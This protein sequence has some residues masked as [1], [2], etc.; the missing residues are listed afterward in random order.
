MVA[1]LK[2]IQAQL[3]DT[4]FAQIPGTGGNFAALLSFT[5]TSAIEKVEFSTG[6]I[7]YEF[8]FVPLPA[9]GLLLFGALG[10]LGVHLAQA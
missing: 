8:A 10:G 7:A 3:S 1:G 2:P 6:T 9:A 5:F 4:Q